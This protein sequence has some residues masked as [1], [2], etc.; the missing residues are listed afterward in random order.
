MATQSG[1]TDAAP[2]LSPSQPHSS[3]PHTHTRRSMKEYVVTEAEL[4]QIS[5][6]NT[7][8]SWFFSAASAA[9]SFAVS[10][11]AGATIQGTLSE[12]ATVF[13]QTGEIVGGVLAA[14]FTGVGI[15]SLR[16]KQ[17]KVSEIRN[18]AVAIDQMGAITARSSTFSQPTPDKEGFP[19]E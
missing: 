13:V 15:W 8:S 2:S 1:A 6:L 3:L 11:Y 7:L 4:D 18:Q 9:A 5:L 10:L 12:G 14:V 17:S 16:K 19:I